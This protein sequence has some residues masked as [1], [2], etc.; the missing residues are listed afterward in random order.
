MIDKL[1]NIPNPST[2]S[3]TEFN[4]KTTAFLNSDL[5]IFI[6]QTN[7][8]IDVMNEKYNAVLMTYTNVQNIQSDVINRQY[9]VQNK[10]SD[11]VAK[12]LDVSD[13]Y[14]A[15]MNY[16]IPTDATYNFDAIDAMNNTVLTEL[17]RQDL[18]INTLNNVL[19]TNNFVSKNQLLAPNLTY[20]EY[21]T[22]TSFRSISKPNANTWFDLPYVKITIPEDGIY[23]VTY[24]ARISQDASTNSFWKKH[25]ILKN[26]TE[27][28]KSVLLG[29]SKNAANINGDS[30]VSKTFIDS[31]VKDDVLQL[32]GYWANNTSGSTVYSNSNGA[33]SIVAIKIG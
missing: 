7:S 23:V 30:T 11:V 21:T 33:T 5:P 3:P 12:S 18:K 14:N 19:N 31:F 16:T 28:T 32:Q 10:H 26:G 17:V 4:E 20:I 22:G 15:V 24:N 25:R 9:D 13:K 8:A 2:Q 29:L 1:K 6:T 27:I